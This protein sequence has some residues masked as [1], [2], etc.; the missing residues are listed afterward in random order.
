MEA[1]K[2][3]ERPACP[4]MSRP[5]GGLWRRRA[6]PRSESCRGALQPPAAIPRARARR[7]APDRRCRRS[8]RRRR[9]PPAAA[10]RRG[11]ATPRGWSPRTA[12]APGG[13]REK[14]GPSPG[15]S[16]PRYGHDAVEMAAQQLERDPADV[17]GPLAVGDRP[18]DRLGGPGDDP[19]RAS[20]SRA[21]AARAGSTP[22]TAA[23][24]RSDFTATATPLRD[25]AAADR[26]QHGEGRG[27]SRGLAF[28]AGSGPA[29]VGP[30]PSTPA[31]R[32]P[33]AAR[34]SRARPCPG[35]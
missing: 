14:R 25:A 30:P 19:P 8:G 5:G 32:S 10:R 9:G 15:R 6:G 3:R 7:T 33:P 26:H 27:G 24:G 11:R 23:S 29:S 2:S 34:R 35:P 18:A 21:S 1:T 31:S 13:P 28:G 4:P 17:R 16:R 12:P 20:E 22:I